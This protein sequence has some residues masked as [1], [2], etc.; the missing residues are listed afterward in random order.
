MTMLE[1]V[2]HLITPK[3]RYHFNN[4]VAGGREYRDYRR[5]VANIVEASWY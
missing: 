3:V 4:I 5:T 2:Q 1:R